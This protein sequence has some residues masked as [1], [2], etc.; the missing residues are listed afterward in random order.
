MLRIARVYIT[1][2]ACKSMWG[3]L[4][5]GCF[6]KTKWGFTEPLE[7]LFY[8]IFLMPICILETLI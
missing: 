6:L 2:K 1:K 5:T 3:G 8:A 7:I 4:V